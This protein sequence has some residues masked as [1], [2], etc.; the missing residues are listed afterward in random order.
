MISPRARRRP[1]RQ[2]I[3]AA[4]VATTAALLAGCGQ[5]QVSSIA[6]SSPTPSSTTADPSAQG[7]ASSSSTPAAKPSP[8]TSATPSRTASPKPSAT[9]SAKPS[10]GATGAKSAHFA[11]AVTFTRAVIGHDYAAA[12]KHASPGS[13]ASR[14][15]HARA[16]LRQA[17]R[18]NGDKLS[19]AKPTVTADSGATSIHISGGDEPGDRWSNFAYDSRGRVTGWSEKSGPIAKV[20]WSKTDKASGLG[21]TATLTSAYASNGS[22]YVVIGYKASAHVGLYY[23]GSYAVSGHSREST[24][25]SIVDSL[26]AHHSVSAYYVFRAA[27]LGGKIT[28][29]ATAASYTRTATLILDVR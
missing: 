12:A 17:E 19:S 10:Q 3:A 1:G 8:K 5:P 28:I 29:T 4:L 16:S 21:L 23:G 27:K 9:G 20:T 6:P 13:A 11:S 7:S 18:S 26:A 15:V 25:S 14:Y 2:L 24:R 22:V